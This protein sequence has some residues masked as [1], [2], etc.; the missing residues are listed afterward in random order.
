MYIYDILVGIA[1]GLILANII[2]FFTIR[3]SE[4]DSI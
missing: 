3:K 1:L 4:N 2:I